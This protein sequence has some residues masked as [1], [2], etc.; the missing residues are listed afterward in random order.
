[1]AKLHLQDDKFMLY[2]NRLNEVGIVFCVPYTK[3][4]KTS[5]RMCLQNLLAPAQYL[6]FE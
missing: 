1:M 6:G 3:L 5:N 4:K 2:L